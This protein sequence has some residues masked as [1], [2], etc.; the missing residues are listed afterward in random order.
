MTASEKTHTLDFLPGGAPGPGE[1]DRVGT[2][3]ATHWGEPPYLVLAKNVSLRKGWE[4][5]SAR[6]P[7]DLS[8]TVDA[9]RDLTDS[10]GRDSR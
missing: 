5:V 1:A 7:P 6:W 8:S 3:V 2:V 10:V 4:A 9:L